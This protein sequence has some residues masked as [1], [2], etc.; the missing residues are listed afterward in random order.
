[1]V[2]WLH[3]QGVS[4][5]ATNFNGWQPIHIAADS[6]RFEVVQWLH[7]QGVPLPATTDFLES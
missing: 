3:E 5:T 6:G 2:Q 1:M 4:L 7:E